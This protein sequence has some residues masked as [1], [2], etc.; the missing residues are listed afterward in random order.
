[1]GYLASRMN[2]PQKHY[3]KKKNTD[4]AHCIS[5]YFMHAM[6]EKGRNIMTNQ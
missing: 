5:F 2:E 3:T 4:T 6:S 1:M